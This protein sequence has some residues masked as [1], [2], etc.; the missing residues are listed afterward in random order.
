MDWIIQVALPIDKG[1]NPELNSSASLIT[2]T[3]L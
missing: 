3:P 1:C 2:E